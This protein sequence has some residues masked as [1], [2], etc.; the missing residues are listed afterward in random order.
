MSNSPYAAAPRGVPQYALQGKYAGRWRESPES[1]Q[2]PAGAPLKY[3]FYFVPR[4]DKAAPGTQPVP[5]DRMLHAANLP[6]EPFAPDGQEPGRVVDMRPYGSARNAR[7]VPHVL[8]AFAPSKGGGMSVFAVPHGTMAEM[9]A[10]A[11][12]IA[13]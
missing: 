13:S 11:Y 10:A 12:A 1:E 2:A 4:G 7:H 6:P 9:R 5:Y 8:W 3:Y